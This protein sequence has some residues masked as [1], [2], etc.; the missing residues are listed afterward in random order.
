[1]INFPKG[2]NKSKFQMYSFYTVTLFPLYQVL[3]YKGIV[4][5]I[6]IMRGYGKV[7]VTFCWYLILYYGNEGIVRLP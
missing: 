5:S 6:F 2:K 7:C 3:V 4:D 1:M